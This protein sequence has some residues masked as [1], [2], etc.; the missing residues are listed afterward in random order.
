MLSPAPP[1]RIPGVLLWPCSG[2]ISGR[3]ADL[4]AVVVEFAVIELASVV[5]FVV[6]ELVI[7]TT[8][9]AGAGSI[10]ASADANAGLTV[11]NALA[12]AAVAAGG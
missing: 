9:D 8:A 2:L 10:N 7:D 3:L 1:A 6:S 11:C 5:K 12:V 4:H